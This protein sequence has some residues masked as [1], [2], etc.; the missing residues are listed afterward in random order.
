MLK[1]DTTSRFMQCVCNNLQSDKKTTE[2]VYIA[3]CAI[4]VWKGNTSV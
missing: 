3:F 2:N 1:C 4:S